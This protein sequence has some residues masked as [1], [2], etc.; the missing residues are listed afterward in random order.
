MNMTVDIIVHLIPLMLSF[1]A[2]L[3]IGLYSA[4]RRDVPGAISFTVFVFSMTSCTIG[5]ILEL[6]SP[7]LKGKIFWDNTQ[8]IGM[9]V[10][11]AA[12]LV[13]AARFTGLGLL[14]SARTAMFLTV[15]PAVS[16]AL[17]F[18]DQFHGLV[19]SAA[20][21]VLGTPFSEL[22]YTFSVAF[23]GMFLY[24]AAA[25]TSSVAILLKKLIRL[26]GPFNARIAVVT[27]G[28]FIPMIGGSLILIGF[29]FTFHRD[30]SPFY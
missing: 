17:A 30:I 28:I 7:G 23:K 20:W 26:S 27:A 4:R 15:V 25:F 2:T 9:F 12:F 29:Q 3:G 22:G 13:F 14:R 10:A 1:G 24:V 8:F 18:T 6:L 16:L 21:I 19:R 5:Y 11:P